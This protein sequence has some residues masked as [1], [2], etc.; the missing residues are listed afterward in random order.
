MPLIQHPASERSEKQISIASKFIWQ[1]HRRGQEGHHRPEADHSRLS[2]NNEMPHLKRAQ[3]PQTA[4]FF[5]KV[6]VHKGSS[7]TPPTA[8]AVSP[9]AGDNT[10]SHRRALS[11]DSCTIRR[12]NKP[13]MEKKR[14]QRINRCLNELKSLVFE[15]VK[16]DPGQYNKLE[17]ADILEMTVRHVQVLHRQEQQFRTLMCSDEGSK[18]KA[19]FTH[20]SSEITKFLKSMGHDIPLDLHHKILKHLNTVVTPVSNVNSVNNVNNCSANVQNSVHV[21]PSQPPI[22]LVLQSQPQVNTTPVVPISQL[23]T[24][25]T[26]PVTQLP[27]NHAPGNSMGAQPTIM[28][29]PAPVNNQQQYENTNT[30]IPEQQTNNMFRTVNNSNNGTVTLVLPSGFPIASNPNNVSQNQQNNIQVVMQQSAQD[31]APVLAAILK[32]NRNQKYSQEYQS[33]R[34]SSNISEC[35]SRLDSEDNS[36]IDTC[37]R[38]SSPVSFMSSPVS[39]MSMSPVPDDR[40]NSPNMYYSSNSSN[41]LSPQTNHPREEIVSSVGAMKYNSCKGQPVIAPKPS[42]MNSTGSSYTFTGNASTRPTSKVLPRFAS[43]TS[44]TSSGTDSSPV[45]KSSKSHPPKEVL[46]MS[47]EM[48]RPW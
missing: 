14:R 25:T 32:S 18:Y 35:Y 27:M 45:R 1:Q 29:V 15:A 22:I 10:F 37:S 4:R 44:H 19:G 16:R 26:M 38:L 41:T 5:A 3:Y 34:I 33:S 17:K 30:L 42:S 9:P 48:W 43:P 31:E 24:A 46:D 23:S 2:K 12:S 36:D 7:A 13:L 8:T 47:P 11:P 6:L 21:A 40:T 28:V 39:F 20:C